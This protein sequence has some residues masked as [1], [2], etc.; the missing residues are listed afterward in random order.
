MTAYKTLT[1][2]AAALRSGQV[3]SVELVQ[4]AIDI[5]DDQD[6]ELGIFLKR[7]NQTAL[8]QAAAADARWAAGDQ[9]GALHGIPIGIKDIISTSEAPSTAQSLVLDQA[10]SDGDAVVVQRLRAA[11]AIIV[12]KL[13]T[14][15]Y[16]IGSPDPAKPF[17]IPRNPWDP[18]RWTG[19][20]SSG[21]GSSVSTGAVLGALGTDT[22]GSIR[23]PAAFCG[24]T[25]LMPTFGRVPKSGC[26]PLG[27]SLDH[28][29]PMARSAR[30][31]AVMLEV[32]AGHHP[33]DPNVAT[34]P[35]DDYLTGLTGDLTGIRIGADRLDRI[36]GA[37]EDPALAAV[38]TDALAALRDRGAEVVDIELPYYREM[39]A[40]DM[41]IMLSEAL[42]YHLPDFQTRWEDYFEATRMT[43]GAGMFYTAADYVQ[44]QRARRVGVKAVTATLRDVDLIITPTAAGG[45][46]PLS[47]TG[48]IGKDLTEG[49]GGGIYTGYWD[50]TGN[51]VLSLPMGFT[52]D[53]L[54]LGLQ[55]AGRPFEEALVLKAG[56]AFQQQTDHHLRLPDRVRSFFSTPQV[57]PVLSRPAGRPR[58]GTAVAA[59]RR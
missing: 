56:D 46:T 50:S 32:L 24:I 55:I 52:D 30:D 8:D 4:Q 22:G 25:G 27:Y 40:A 58:V 28:I 1:E 3:T 20:S 31:C 36:G 9:V 43:V 47:E 19:G 23:I 21:S 54:P 39:A 35:V 5:A 37:H 26:V 16:A 59:G 2:A 49:D 51:P 6:A 7:F 53:G 12:G 38:W 10:W 45:A 15:E 41:V 14:M 48:A 57:D 44:A 33:S 34:D 13:T 29:G 11:G 17:P 42:A 18:D